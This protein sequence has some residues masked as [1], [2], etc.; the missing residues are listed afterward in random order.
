MRRRSLIWQS[1]GKWMRSQ[2]F[3][4]QGFWSDLLFSFL[5]T[6]LSTFFSLLLLFARHSESSA[7]TILE[8][9]RLIEE[10][11]KTV[12]EKTPKRNN[13]ELE[14]SLCRLRGLRLLILLL[15]RNSVQESSIFVKL[16]TNV[17]RFI[18]LPG[19]FVLSSLIRSLVHLSYSFLAHLALL[20]QHG[21]QPPPNL[22]I[23]SPPEPQ[24]KK[25]GDA[26]D[27][28]FETKGDGENMI[29]IQ[30]QK[31]S[32]KTIQIGLC[33]VKGVG[34]RISELFRHVGVD[35]PLIALFNDSSS[36]FISQT[37]EVLGA[38]RKSHAESVSQLSSANPAP[39]HP[40]L[41]S[42][43]FA[44]TPPTTLS[45]QA[46]PD[47]IQIVVPV[48]NPIFISSLIG[49]SFC[50]FDR[51]P[52]SLR[53][54]TDS[55][56]ATQSTQLKKTPYLGTSN[57]DPFLVVDKAPLI[58]QDTHAG[59]RTLC[60]TTHTRCVR[61][62]S[63]HIARRLALN[64]L[65]VMD[66]FRL[67]VCETGQVE[68]LFVLFDLVAQSTTSTHPVVFVMPI[69][70]SVLPRLCDTTRW[71]FPTSLTKTTIRSIA[72]ILPAH[73]TSFVQWTGCSSLVA[74]FFL[75]LSKNPHLVE[76]S[77]S[78]NDSKTVLALHAH[79]RSPTIV[80]SLLPHK[81]SKLLLTD[82]IVSVDL[83]F[84]FLASVWSP[85][86]TEWWQIAEDDSA[87]AGTFSTS[88]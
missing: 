28:V 34:Q 64:T 12:F 73:L 23:P 5:W 81:L 14:T 78:L 76:D 60:P 72:N 43:V 61:L 29:A 55:I 26:E 51:R 41:S 69:A 2:Y 52:C 66:G 47:T 38:L 20:L 87:I 59:L 44:I 30:A 62:S 85:V 11:K 86:R 82:P 48:L 42:N 35:A 27:L 1:F 36:S 53:R 39:P 63:L 56:L 67:S 9:W 54:Y 58:P 45:F 19:L 6:C 18:L 33:H 65:V 10:I 31:E 68:N 49:E 16:S 40:A 71:I 4:R 15:G 13:T 84:F 79:L 32:D 22:P 77:D 8:C 50:L 25:T 80:D 57:S 21:K 46:R 83:L 7:N 75:A 37:F 74:A 3:W 88:W 70:S 24:E 17:L